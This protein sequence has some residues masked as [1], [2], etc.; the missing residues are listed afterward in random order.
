MQEMTKMASEAARNGVV[1]DQETLEEMEMLRKRLL[2]L[3]AENVVKSLDAPVRPGLFFPWVS[4]EASGQTWL[5][6]VVQ[7]ASAREVE[8]M[9]EELHSL[10]EQYVTP[11]PPGCAVVESAQLA[12]C[13]GPVVTSVP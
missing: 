6:R 10:R 4:V 11:G 7:S 2:E 13:L 9:E 12:A 1:V 3:E 8:Y 5:Y